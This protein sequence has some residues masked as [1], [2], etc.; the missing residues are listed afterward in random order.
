MKALYKNWQEELKHSFTSIEQLP[1]DF[2]LTNDEKNFLQTSK[3]ESL[4]KTFLP[5]SITP[6]FLNAIKQSI[7]K[8]NSPNIVLNPLRR[9]VIPSNDEFTILPCE[10]SDPLGEH[11]Y[12]PCERLVHQYKNRVLLLTTGTCVSYCRHCFRR[13]FTSRKEGS[14][15]D[16]QLSTICKYLSVHPEIK[17]ILISGGDPLT[18]EDKKLFTILKEIRKARPNILLRICTRAPVF[19]PSRFT[20]SLIKIFSS[21]KPLWIIPHINHPDELTTATKKA[22][23][24]CISKGIPIQ[25]QTVLLKGVNDSV[26]TLEELFETLTSLG[27]KPGYLFQGDLAPGTSHL[28]VSLSDGL[29]IYKELE[30]RLSGLSLPTYAVDLPDGGGKIPLGGHVPISVTEKDFVF[31]SKNG[32]TYTYPNL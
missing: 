28:R 23:T 19:L 21:L 20:S 12:S 1:K 14:I 13:T 16:K 2:E 4:E 3:N 29:K 17:E 5:F 31:E 15:T 7:K 30:K 27:I 6:S 9:Q 22:L 11:H 10:L 32:E 25:S 24:A 26:D 18:L 8:Q